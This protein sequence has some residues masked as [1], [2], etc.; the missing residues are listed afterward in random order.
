MKKYRLKYVVL[1]S[2]G[3]EESIQEKTLFGWKTIIRGI[4]RR[5]YDFD[6]QRMMRVCIEKYKRNKALKEYKPK[7]IVVTRTEYVQLSA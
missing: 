5:F 2:G 1:S 4:D 6:V 3:V 7:P